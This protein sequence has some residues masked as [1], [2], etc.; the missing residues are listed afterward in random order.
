MWVLPKVKQHNFYELLIYQRL[1]AI[2]DLFIHKKG[3]N[4]GVF[5]KNV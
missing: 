2:F 3:Q 4:K 5:R 1:Q